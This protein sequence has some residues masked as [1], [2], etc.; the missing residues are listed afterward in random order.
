MSVL[1]AQTKIKAGFFCLFLC[2]LFWK[3]YFKGTL[4]IH[5]VPY[6]LKV[7]YKCLWNS[8]PPLVLFKLFEKLAWWRR[9]KLRILVIIKSRSVPN[10][11][12]LVTQVAFFLFCLFILTPVAPEQAILFLSTHVIYWSLSR[13]QKWRLI[14]CRK[15]WDPLKYFKQSLIVIVVPAL[16]VVVLPA[17]FGAWNTLLICY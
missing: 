10:K 7:S 12:F 11:T 17:P 14:L 9:C 2:L 3:L 13:G 6:L 1:W 4:Y 5:S 8:Q 16:C 15:F